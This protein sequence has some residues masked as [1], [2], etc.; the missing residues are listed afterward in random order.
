HR[1]MVTVGESP[2]RG[3]RFRQVGQYRPRFRGD[4]CWCGPAMLRRCGIIGGSAAPP[5]G[6]P[7]GVDPTRLAEG[8]LPGEGPSAYHRVLWLTHPGVWPPGIW[9]GP[10]SWSLDQENAMTPLIAPTDTPALLARA[11]SLCADSVAL[12][13]NLVTVCAESRALIERGRDRR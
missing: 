12:G 8:A 3:N 6:A 9:R 7:W 5:P 10:S 4:C 2:R 11:A 13:A 1:S